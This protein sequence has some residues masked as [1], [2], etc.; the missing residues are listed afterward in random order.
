MLTDGIGTFVDYLHIRGILV[1]LEAREAAA[2]IGKKIALLVMAGLF[3]AI[4]YFGIVIALT[5]WAVKALQ[6]SWPVGIAVAGGLHLVVGIAAFLM[7]RQYPGEPLFRDTLEELEKDRKWLS[8][9]EK[10]KN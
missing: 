10:S 1:R 2:E 9:K 4:G 3:L 8:K 5:V 6:W 7:S